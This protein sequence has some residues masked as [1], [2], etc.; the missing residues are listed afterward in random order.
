M[1]LQ[2]AADALG[3]HYQTAYGWVRSGLL[4]AR[5]V[6]HGYQISETDVTALVEQRRRGSRPASQIRVRDWQAQ[7]NQVYLAIADGGEAEARR[8]IGRL[9]GRVSVADLCDEVLGPALRRIG[10]DW[11]AGQVSIAQEHRATAI[12]ERLLATHAPRP[13]GRPRG[14]AVVSTPP[15][16][17][18]A[19]PALMA[20]ACLREDHWQVQ[21]LSADLPA[22]EI[23][24]MARQVGAALVVLSTASTGGALRADRAARVIRR[25][26]PHAVLL[27]GRSGETL[28]ALRAQTRQVAG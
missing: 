23:G 7:A 21:H 19:M 12:C 20:A 14:T 26:A 6:G 28:R 17:R 4:P 16:E 11:A 27:I 18:H 3:V 10:D 25:L 9:A 8:L 15:G 1:D 24:T 13:A 5:K 2:A 22:A